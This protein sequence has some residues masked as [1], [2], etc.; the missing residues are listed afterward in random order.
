MVPGLTS[1]GGRLPGKGDGTGP[2]AEEEKEAYGNEGQ[3]LEV[4]DVVVVN[5]EGKEHACMIGVLKMGSAEMKEKKKGVAIENGHFVG[6]G[7]WKL[8]V[9]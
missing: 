9:S 5:A 2:L 3:E 4:G 6:D 1:A 7:L 8:D